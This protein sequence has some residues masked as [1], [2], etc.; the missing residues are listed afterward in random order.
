[1]V[2]FA[3]AP[4]NGLNFP[5]T[6]QTKWTKTRWEN[7]NLARTLQ[8]RCCVIWSSTTLPGH[9]L[10][11]LFRR[12]ITLWTSYMCWFLL[13]QKHKLA[14]K[15]WIKPV[16]QTLIVQRKK[17]TKRIRGRDLPTVQADFTGDQPTSPLE[18]DV[19]WLVDTVRCFS[20]NILMKKVQG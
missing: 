19:P 11:G 13:P 5:T 4:K 1:M 8:I 7:W 16:C 14:D 2:S 15:P 10:Y 9:L 20:W 3:F 6:S 18:R 12:Y 17:A